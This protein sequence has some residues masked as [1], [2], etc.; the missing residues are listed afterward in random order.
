MQTTN[1][2]QCDQHSKN[3]EYNILWE[4]RKESN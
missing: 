1:K 4:L 2:T 3:L